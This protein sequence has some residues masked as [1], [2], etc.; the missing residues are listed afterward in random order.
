MKKYVLN[1]ERLYSGQTANAL[2]LNQVDEDFPVL[3]PS[4][5]KGTRNWN[6]WIQKFKKIHPEFNPGTVTSLDQLNNYVIDFNLNLQTKFKESGHRELYMMDDT[7]MMKPSLDEDATVASDKKYMH[8]IN[9]KDVVTGFNSSQMNVLF[10]FK[11]MSSK[12]IYAQQLRVQSIDS[13][14]DSLERAKAI[15][16]QGNVSYR[17]CLRDVQFI[18][19]NIYVMSPSIDIDGDIPQ[20]HGN[21]L[22]IVNGVDRP[23][24]FPHSMTLFQ[25]SV[26]SLFD[27]KSKEDGEYHDKGDYIVEVVQEFKDWYRKHNRKTVVSLDEETYGGNV[28]RLK[29][30]DNGS[31]E[32]SLATYSP[33]DIVDGQGQWHHLGEDTFLD[34]R[35]AEDG[36][37]V[38]GSYV[39]DNQKAGGVGFMFNLF[40]T[41]ITG[42]D[43]ILRIDIPVDKEFNKLMVKFDCK[44][45]NEMYGPIEAVVE[46]NET[47]KFH[48]DS[49]A[50][51]DDPL[52]GES[53]S[54]EFT[55]H[56]TTVGENHVSIAVRIHHEVDFGKR[57]T[58]QDY[59]AKLMRSGV[60]L[61]NIRVEN[62]YVETN[63]NL[64]FGS[65]LN[66]PGITEDEHERRY[67]QF[68]VV[69]QFN[70]DIMY[71]T[72]VESP[73]KN[74]LS[75]GMSYSNNYSSGDLYGDM[76]V[77]KSVLD[78]KYNM[79]IWSIDSSNELLSIG[80]DYIGMGSCS[81]QL[82]LIYKPTDIEIMIDKMDGAKTTRRDSG[83]LKYQM[84]EVVKNINRFESSIKHKMNV[85]SV[86]V[87]NSNLAP[88]DSDTRDEPLEKFKK[89]LR[90]SVTQFVRN[91][92]DGIVPVH[93]QL[94]D[95]QF[96]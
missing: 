63:G 96:T 67:G 54:V 86:V 92:C 48:Y 78:P 30:L 18:G 70:R 95:V 15:T 74:V 82:S 65:Y 39:F 71:Q 75:N 28:S 51:E 36:S 2:V 10:P 66:E 38:D 44:V 5:P 13:I 27:L 56:D 53:G 62:G 93:T 35:A 43:R 64:T 25:T 59:R 21:G 76:F 24:Y 4:V 14:D 88:D 45:L 89:Q 6:A 29:C 1:I 84:V 16:L 49:T 83:N 94:F 41:F 61:S 23:Y 20:I 91:T 9:G 55:V 47:P 52:S 19:G 77:T 42:K 12:S 22:T 79:D 40:D 46:V 72:I 17:D 81:N 34:M 73:L 68:W 58:E 80:R 32:I 33:T 31:Y 85:F 26:D 7:Q 87:E 90:N 8:C 50:N 37:Y 11:K 57:N 60:L 69:S 3:L